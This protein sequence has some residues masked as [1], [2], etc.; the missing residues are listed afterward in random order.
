LQGLT[1][2]T[3]VVS[4][5]IVDYLA[6]LG[7]RNKRCRGTNEELERELLRLFPP[8]DSELVCAPCVVVDSEGRILL[9]YLPGLLALKSQVRKTL[10]LL[11]KY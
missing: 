10:Q 4:W 7:R 11:K 9:W 2:C 3:E 8:L 5:S 1:V 6:E